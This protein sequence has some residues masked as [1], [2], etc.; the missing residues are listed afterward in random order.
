MSLVDHHCHGVLREPLDRAAFESWLCEADAP[1]PW[2]GTLFDTQVGFAVRRFCAPLLDLTPHTE[3]D[4]YLERRA[5][6]GP[7]EVSRRLLTATGIFQFL[8]DTG[9]FADQLTSPDELAAYTGATAREVVRLEMVAEQVI[10]EHDPIVFADVCRERLTAAAES[11]IAFKSIAAY[12]VGLDLDPARP[13]EAAVVTAVARWASDIQHGA[14]PRLT[15]ETVIRFLI[16]AAIDLG[17]PIQ[18]H[19]GYGDADTDLAR[20][21]PLLLTPL[22]R[23]TAH[24]GVPIMLL[25]TYPFHRHAG[26]LAQVFDH[27]FVDIG[28]AVQNVGTGTGRV[29]TELLELAPFGSVLFST[30]GCGLPELFHVS[31]VLFRQALADVLGAGVAEDSWSIADAERIARMIGVGNAH[32]AYRL[33]S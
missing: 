23:A 12:R 10:P 3:P 33:G 16:W 13:S 26:Y 20:A 1:G 17:M 11:A 19:T 22:L 28:L 15:D 18:F 7:A 30:D 9:F 4:A 8:V 32:R 21:D 24:H 27:V 2:H 31:T 6:L 5:E 14:T 29:L 25:H